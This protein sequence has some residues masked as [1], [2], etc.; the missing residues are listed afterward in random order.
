MP[1]FFAAVCSEPDPSPVKQWRG[2]KRKKA[3][4]ASEARPSLTQQMFAPL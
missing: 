4:E 2:V 3:R 1:K